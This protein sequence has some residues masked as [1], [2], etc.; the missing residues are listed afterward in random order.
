MVQFGGYTLPVGRNAQVLAM[1]YGIDA[2]R[3]ML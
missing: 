1:L 3:E 2:D